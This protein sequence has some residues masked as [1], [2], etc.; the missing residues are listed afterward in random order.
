METGFIPYEYDDARCFSEGLASVEKDKKWGYIDTTGNLVIP[1]EY[2]F[3][4]YFNEGLASV[5]N[6]R[7]GYIDT[8]G[9]T[10]I[11]FEYNTANYGEGYFTLL[12]DGE[13]SI[14][15]RDEVQ[16]DWEEEL[17]TREQTLTEQAEARRIEAEKQKML[18][19]YTDKETIKATQTALNAAGYDCGTPD[20]I[21][22]KGT[23]RAVTNYQ[24]DKGLS[25][26]TGKARRPCCA[27]SICSKCRTPASCT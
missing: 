1:Y 21:A 11:P 22:G 23:A 4:D 5:I 24:T 13:I 6:Y 10:I 25:F 8:T 12:K 3:A 27:A 9:K 26:R 18:K 19:E 17:A 7:S 20:G 15:S 2:S 16:P 14:I